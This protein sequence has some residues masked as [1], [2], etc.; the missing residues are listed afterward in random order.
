MYEK[1]S[2]FFHPPKKHYTVHFP[3]PSFHTGA[4][5]PTPSL[6]SKLGITFDKV[7]EM[8]SIVL[9]PGPVMITPHCQ[10]SRQTSRTIQRFELIWTHSGCLPPFLAQQES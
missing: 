1:N 7:D 4:V 6:G 10:K 2:L 8:E 9:D 5:G 3:S